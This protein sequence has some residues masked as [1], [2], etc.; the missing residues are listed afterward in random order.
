M[1]KEEMMTLVNHLITENK[2]NEFLDCIAK[3]GKVELVLS[4]LNPETGDVSA[5]FLGKGKNLVDLTTGIAS[6]L[7]EKKPIV[8][9]YLVTRLIEENQKQIKDHNTNSKQ[10]IDFLPIFNMMS[11]DKNILN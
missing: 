11:N 8:G 3:T 10:N 4:V 6:K 9:L 2:W 5:G 1:K 7:I